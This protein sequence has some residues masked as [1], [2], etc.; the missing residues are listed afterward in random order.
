MGE[1]GGWVG[2][3]DCQFQP[4]LNQIMNATATHKRPLPPPPTTLSPYCCSQDC[5]PLPE[6][7]MNAILPPPTHTHTLPTPTHT[8]PAAVILHCIHCSTRNVFLVL[9]NTPPT[10]VAHTFLH[11]AGEWGAAAVTLHGRTRQQRYSRLA[12]WDYIAQ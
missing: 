6:L 5:L 7:A 11:R 4:K 1:M 9:F 12:D 3:G 8:P 2:G 10:Q